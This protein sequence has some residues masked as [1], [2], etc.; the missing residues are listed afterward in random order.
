MGLDNFVYIRAK[1]KYHGELHDEEF[2]NIVDIAEWQYKKNGVYDSV[3]YSADGFGGEVC[4]WR[5]CWGFRNRVMDYLR[6][7]YS[8]K[9]R[10]SCEWNLDVE[11]LQEI[12]NYIHDYM[13]TSDAN[14]STIWSYRESLQ[15][16]ATT[17]ANLLLLI[18]DIENGAISMKDIDILW[19]DSY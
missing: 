19:V 13:I 11:D 14:F 8:E 17:Y 3:G 1:E 10:D 6:S 7:K 2:E 5:K 18:H 15:H 4:Y 12:A 16:N 9:D